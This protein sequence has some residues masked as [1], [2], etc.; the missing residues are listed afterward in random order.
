MQNLPT[1]LSTLVLAFAC[2]STAMAAGNG[3]GPAFT[4]PP[5]GDK[6]FALMGEFL[7]EITP[8]EG[9]KEQLGLQL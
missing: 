4:E 7:G 3:K 8:A 2:T 6:D 9:Q 5:K 1:L